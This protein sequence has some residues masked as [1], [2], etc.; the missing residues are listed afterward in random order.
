ALAAA[1]NR[2]LPPNVGYA[3]D[4]IDGERLRAKYAVMT[5]AQFRRGMSARSL[6]TT[7]WTRFSQPCACVYA[8]SEQDRGAVLAAVCAA[9]MTAAQWAAALGPARAE[10]DAYWSALY[11]QTY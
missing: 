5:L 9:A 2:L 4:E 1:A 6:D 7:L 11:A 3:E 8:R 10:P